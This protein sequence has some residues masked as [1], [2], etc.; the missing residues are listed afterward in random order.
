[1][2]ITNNSL[3]NIKDVLLRIITT[4]NINAAIKRFEK[5]IEIYRIHVDYTSS[6]SYNLFKNFDLSI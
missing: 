1:M 2:I 4:K 5:N 6:F 3:N